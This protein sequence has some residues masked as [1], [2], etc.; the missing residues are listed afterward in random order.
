MRAPAAFAPRW[1]WAFW[2]AG[3]RAHMIAAPVLEFRYYGPVEGR[4]VEIDRSSSDALRITLDRVVLEDVAPDKDAAL[5]CA[6]RCMAR[7]PVA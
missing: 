1:P 3:L 6:S 2:S 4:V 7:Q 5:W